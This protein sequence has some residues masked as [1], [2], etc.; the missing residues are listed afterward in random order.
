MAELSSDELF[1]VN[2]IG[3]R[4]EAAW[5]AGARPR[6]EEFVTTHQGRLR[7]AV[8][9][10]LVGIELELLRREGE[11]PSQASYE[12]RFPADSDLVAAV[13][14]EDQGPDVEGLRLGS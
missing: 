2:D 4:F 10:H 3:D 14:A 8:V 5:R 13:F 9:K 6:I 12:R 1:R 11:H 7:Q